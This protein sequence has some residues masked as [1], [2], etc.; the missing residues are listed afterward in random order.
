MKR[1]AVGCVIHDSWIS[2][3]RFRTPEGTSR[4][5]NEF[6]KLDLFNEEGGKSKQDLY[7]LGLSSGQLGRSTDGVES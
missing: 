2:N 3:L 7:E 6:L 1:S 4:G 5:M